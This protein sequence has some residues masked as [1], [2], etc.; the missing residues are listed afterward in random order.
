VLLNITFSA[1]CVVI[2]LISLHRPGEGFMLC[3]N[4]I[5][6]PIFKDIAWDDT[7]LKSSWLINSKGLANQHCRCHQKICRQYQRLGKGQL[8]ANNQG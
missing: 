2:S 3:N 7:P 5:G 8:L 1:S 6:V 4:I